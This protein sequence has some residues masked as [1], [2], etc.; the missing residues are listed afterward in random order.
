MD[1]LDLLWPSLRRVMVE[2]PDRGGGRC[3]PLDGGTDW[4]AFCLGYLTFGDP[5]GERGGVFWWIDLIN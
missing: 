1:T 5:L 2:L 4:L 3:V